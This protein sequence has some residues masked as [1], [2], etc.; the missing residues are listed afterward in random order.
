[1]LVLGQT[2]RREKVKEKEVTKLEW[3][4]LVL[5]VNKGS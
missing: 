5:M 1:M 3:G 2:A 4:K